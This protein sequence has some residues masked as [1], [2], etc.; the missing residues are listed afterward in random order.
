MT[1]KS[2]SWGASEITE[3][4]WICYSATA[5]VVCSLGA[6]VFQRSS[7]DSDLQPELGTAAS[8]L[9]NYLINSGPGY[10]INSSPSQ[11]SHCLLMGEMSTAPH[12]SSSALSSLCEPEGF[13]HGFSSLTGTCAL[14]PRWNATR[15]LFLTLFTLV[16]F[17]EES[18]T[19]LP[20]NHRVS[21][22]LTNAQSSLGLFLASF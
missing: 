19:K 14:A 13:S 9:R 21:F 22:F 1:P 4:S 16:T 8:H 7:D 15:L 2:I 18:T 12:S 5:L 20:N 11:S 17:W 3:L 10:L 6:G